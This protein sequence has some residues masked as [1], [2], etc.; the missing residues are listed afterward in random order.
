MVGVFPENPVEAAAPLLYDGKEGRA[1][2][3]VRGAA[4]WQKVD[5]TEC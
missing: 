5:R 4:T 1:I 3:E 2:V